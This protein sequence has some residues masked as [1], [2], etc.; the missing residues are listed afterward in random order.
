MLGYF[1]DR[2]KTMSD[3]LEITV[4]KTD[5]GKCFLTTCKASNGYDFTYH[6]SEI[7][8][9][10]FDGKQAKQSNAPHWY[11]VPKYPE[12]IQRKVTGAGEN[13]RYEL[14]DASMQ[15]DKLPL[16]ITDEER[17][18]YSQRVLDS[19]YVY[20]HDTIPDY[21]RDVECDLSILC[22]VS[23][24]IEP[25]EF[26]YSAIKKVDFSNVRYTITN[27]DI[28]HSIVDRVIL[29]AP[30]LA[31]SPCKLTSKEMYDITRQFI[32]DNID[33]SQARITSDYNFCFTVKKVI[34]LLAPETITYQNYFA[35]TKKARSKIHYAT[36]EVKEVEIFQMTHTQ[37]N[38]KGYT[39]IKEFVAN[40]EWELKEKV[41]EFLNNLINI[42]NKPIH[43]CPQCSGIGYIEE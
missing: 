18:N 43:I 17:K 6:K 5:S 27:L 14:L 24:F 13:Y 20:K 41:D 15:S 2:D 31:N 32:K 38:Y 9:L 26:N 4:I 36:K 25:P 22:E 21:F 40:N 23:N 8:I 28:K 30:L 3:K 34:P 33:K 42:I 35:K 1:N 29:P 7:P 10:Y 37:E 39:P 16:T 12:K 19:L 11:E